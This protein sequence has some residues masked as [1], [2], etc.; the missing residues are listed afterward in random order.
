MIFTPVSS[1]STFFHTFLS[2]LISV[3]FLLFFQKR[4]ILFLLTLF[5]NGSFLLIRCLAIEKA[6]QLCHTTPLR[7]TRL[8]LSHRLLPLKHS[9]PRSELHPEMYSLHQMRFFCTSVPS[10]AATAAKSSPAFARSAIVS[11]V[12]F[13]FAFSSSVSSVTDPDSS[14]DV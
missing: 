10:S 7:Q 9:P 5:D 13:A 3:S 1:K 11:A 6:C 12:D 4:I 14:V 8:H 2:T